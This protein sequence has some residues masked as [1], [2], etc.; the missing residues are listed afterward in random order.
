MTFSSGYLSHSCSSVF[1]TDLEQR[2]SRLAVTAHLR[3]S[4]VLTVWTNP[5]K[6]RIIVCNLPEVFVSTAGSSSVNARVLSAVA[7]TP[8]H[9]HAGHVVQLYKDDSF[10]VDVLARFVGGALAAGDTALIVATASHRVELEKRLFSRGLSV[11]KAEAQGRYIV[12]DAPETLKKFMV[13]GE[14]DEKRFVDVIGH[15]LQQAHKPAVGGQDCRLAVFGELVALLWSDGRWSQA[16]RVEQ[17]WND[18]AKKYSF[19]LLCAYPITGFDN[20]GQSGPFLKMCKEHAGVIPSEHYLGLS[21]E[22]E[23]LRNIAELQHKTRLL[24]QGLVLHE[25]EMRFRLLVEAVQDYAIF[26]LDPKGNVST[27]N[28]GAERIKG[29]KADEIIGK[30]FSTFYPPEDKLND[31]PAWEL[32]VAEKEGRFEDEGW[33]VRKDGSKFWANVIITALKDGSGKL[34]GFAKITR[35]FTERIRTQQVLEKE[36]AE[37]REAQEK[38]HNSEKSLR[39]LS[40]HL[41]RTQDEERRRI[42]RDLHDSL[43]Q[44]LAVLKMKLDS[45]AAYL[46]SVDTAAAQDVA[47][48]IRL[49]DDSIKEVR[50]V[51]YLLYPPMLEEMGLKSAIPWYLDGFSARSGIGTTFEVQAD[52]SRLPKDTELALFR[53]LQESLTNV[54]RHSESPIAH[55]RLSRKDDM[56]VLE[57]EDKGKGVAR[58]L[59]EQSGPDWMGALGVGVRGMNERM[60]Q[61]GGKLEIIS[62]AAGTKVLGSIPLK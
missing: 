53:I 50:T 9:G 10:L 27:W 24:E 31:K 52:F 55:V 36:V 18:L 22:E 13:N 44:Y 40:R 61:L 58:E 42:G 54:H 26:M 49:T 38:L 5:S 21:T 48:C 28:I 25:S 1:P 17:L 51:S 16:I 15:A 37:R 19:S 3:G 34:I 8:N 2:P 4:K 35:D 56:C 41:L 20:D 43:G 11:I 57:V 45:V 59:L 39:E 62:S 30:H 7:H 23:R 60:R 14:V 32:V 12:L 33:R 29:Y 6:N 47:Q 46:G